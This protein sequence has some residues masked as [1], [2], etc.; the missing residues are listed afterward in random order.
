M[1]TQI[2]PA[3]TRELSTML[4]QVLRAAKEDGL[5]LALYGSQARGTARP[6]SDT[7]VLQLVP[8]RP[9]G[10]ANQSVNVTAYLPHTLMMMAERG[11]LFVLHL[12]TEAKILSDPHGLLKTILDAYRPPSSYEPLIAQIRASSAALHD[13]SDTAKYGDKLRHLG[14]YLLRTTL[15]ARLAERGQPTFDLLEAANQL[16]NK[17]VESALQLRRKQAEPSDDLAILRQALQELLG[18]LPDNPWQSVEA[19]A[20]GLSRNTPYAAALLAQT[21]FCDETGLEYTAL[22]PP[23][24]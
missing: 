17:H 12:K 16:G 15:Y 10:Y 22:T 5:A 11:S 8:H 19:L 20:V 2:A 4:D 23:P 14:I 18:P 9:G 24:L 21:L 6:D 7:D 3:R 13:V 1:S